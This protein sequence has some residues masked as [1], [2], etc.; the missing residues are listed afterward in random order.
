MG[1]PGVAVGT[2]VFAALVWIDRELERNVRRLVARDDTAGLNL[3]ALGQWGGC[4]D[5]V[6]PLGCKRRKATAP[7]AEGAS[8]T[9]V[10]ITH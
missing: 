4:D 8:A 7:V 6:I 3:A 2:P 9:A 1:W 10:L 5:A